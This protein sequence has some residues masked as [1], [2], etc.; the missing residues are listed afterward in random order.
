MINWRRGGDF[1]TNLPVN[2]FLVVLIVF[3]VEKYFIIVKS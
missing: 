3:I 1:S 2:Y